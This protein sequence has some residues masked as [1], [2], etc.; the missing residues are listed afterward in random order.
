[1]HSSS[2]DNFE[3]RFSHL[4]LDYSNHENIQHYVSNGWCS[5]S[6]VWPECWPKF[7]HLFPHGDVDITNL[8]ERLW[9][10]V[11]YTLLDVM[12]N[13]SALDLLHALVGNAR[14]G[15][16]MGGT[17]LEFFK[18]K[19]Q[20]GELLSHSL[21]FLFDLSLSKVHGMFIDSGFWT[22]CCVWF[23][24]E[25]NKGTSCSGEAMSMTQD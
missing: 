14:S 20:L 16:W 5:K 4:L 23:K 18:Q 10:Y 13:R 7:G 15:S 22:I 24:Q 3:A 11:K 9:Q 19:Q 21:D 8:V 2:E 17:L 12:I 25:C 6:C 1:M